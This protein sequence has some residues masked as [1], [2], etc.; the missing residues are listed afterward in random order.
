MPN[1]KDP[2]HV[3]E[4]TGTADEIEKICNWASRVDPRFFGKKV[5]PGKLRLRIR[6][7]A[8]EFAPNDLVV[9]IKRKAGLLKARPK[10]EP[11]VKVT[12][13]DLPDGDK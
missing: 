1:P 6:M 13:E 2:E 3:I 9:A 5:T 10:Q 11:K 8:N 12:K 7:P 4:L